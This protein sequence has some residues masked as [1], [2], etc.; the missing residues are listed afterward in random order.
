[1]LQA[2]FHHCS[3]V[4]SAFT[5]PAGPSEGKSFCI[6]MRPIVDQTLE[7]VLGTVSYDRLAHTEQQER[8]MLNAVGCLALTFTYLHSQDLVWQKDIKPRDI[9]IHGSKIYLSDFGFLH[10]RS[11]DDE[12]R[13]TPPEH[14][15]KGSGPTRNS[16]SDIFS[17]GATFM[18]ILRVLSCD[19]GKIHLEHG[20]DFE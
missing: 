14:R 9:L 1:M 4:C 13:Y 20:N 7:K 17:L 15:D 10:V 19:E 16:T 8:V 11:G 6:A 18:A 3:E 2:Q 12:Y 5:L